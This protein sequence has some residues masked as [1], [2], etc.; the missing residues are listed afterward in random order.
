[1]Q[2]DAAGRGFS[3]QRDEPLDMRMDRS[4][5]DTAADLLARSTE[6]EIADAIYAYGEER[7]SRRIARA[8]V[9]ERIEQPID[10]T[11][12]WLRSCAGRSRG[13][14]ISASIRRHGR[15]RRFASG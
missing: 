3:F 8:I 4:E 11:A 13:A 14:G 7:F 12:G 6:V 1:M 5:G 10:T 15:F 9:R 2:F